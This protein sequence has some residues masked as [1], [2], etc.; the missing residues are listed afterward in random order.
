MIIAEKLAVEILKH[1][2]ILQS[3]LP[4]ILGTRD[5]RIAEAV[6]IL[7]SQNKIKRNKSGKSYILEPIKSTFP[8]FTSPCFGCHC[9]PDYPTICPKLTDWLMNG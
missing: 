7:I 5:Q 1:L 6:K 8:F 4:H 9:D 2:P 3:K